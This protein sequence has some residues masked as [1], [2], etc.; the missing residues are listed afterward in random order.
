MSWILGCS[1]ELLTKVEADYPLSVQAQSHAYRVEA[2]GTV[3]ST[4]RLALHR[5]HQGDRGKLWIVAGEQTQGVGRRGRIWHS[6]EGNLYASLLLVA[7]YAAE[8]AALLG[9]VAGV[10]LA[11]TLGDLTGCPAK[12]QLKWPND[13]LLDGAKLT[14][15]LVERHPLAPFSKNGDQSSDKNC[16]KE[17]GQGQLAIIIGIGINV[18]HAP[19][20]PHYAVTSLRDRGY[21]ITP[22]QI[23]NRLSQAWSINFDLWSEGGGF[24]PIREKWLKFAAGLGNFIQV[25]RQGETIRGIFKTIDT[26]GRLMIERESGDQVAISAG[27]VHFGDAVTSRML[28]IQGQE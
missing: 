28:P 5:A 1:K 26:Q 7:N 19:Q 23:F 10:A 3:T 8:Q 18:V 14:G 21:E 6:P 27:D 22:A 11:E 25:Q 2:H 4:N 9:F 20:Q 17:Q 15:I 16:G 24:P 13:V 12:I